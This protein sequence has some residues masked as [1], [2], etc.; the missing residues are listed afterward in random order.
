MKKILFISH[1]LDL[2][3]S[4]LLLKNIVTRLDEKLFKRTVFSP[5]DGEL[6]QVYESKDIEVIVKDFK[7]DSINR[8]PDFSLQND[9]LRNKILNIISYCAKNNCKLALRCA[10]TLTEKILNEFDFSKVQITGIY[11][12]NPALFGKEIKSIRVYPVDEIAGH[13]PDAVLILH[14]KPNF[15][16]N[17]LKAQGFKKVYDLSQS[18]SAVIKDFASYIFSLSEPISLFA[19]ENPNIIFVN[20]ARTFW[21]VI[22]GKLIGKKVI[23][24]IHEGFDP[25]TFRVKPQSLYFLSLRIADRFIFPSRAAYEFYKDFIPEKKVSIIPNGIDIQEIERF[26]EADNLEQ[27]KKELNISEN[28]RVICTIATMQE[29]KGQLYF[30]KAAFNLL[31]N[32]QNKN[33]IFVLVGALHNTYSENISQMI[34]SSEFRDNFRIVPVTKEAYKYFNI[35]DIYVTSSFSETFCLS[36]IEAMAFRKPVIATKVCGIPETIE[37]GITGIL[38]PSENMEY[39][40]SQKIEYLLENPDFA[41]QISNSAYNKLKEKFI[42]QKTVEK[43]QELLMLN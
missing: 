24:A 14:A 41:Q 35:A 10:G 1:N 13:K 28:S 36:N 4:Q 20:N 12:T 6:S 8:T 15:L 23:W 18:F 2:G 27:T 33:L 43:Y 30:V 37:D 42:I 7:A 22:A 11:D 29:I 31:K 34:D 17:Q 38:I 3:G 32:S 5:T 21:A 19:G 9:G 25:K 40:I 26:I 16:K 39:H